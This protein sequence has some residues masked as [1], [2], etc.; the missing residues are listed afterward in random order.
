[1][2]LLVSDFD[3]TFFDDNYLDNIKFV[4]SIRNNTKFVIATGRN[5]N[6]LKKS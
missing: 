2:N 3:G 1:M 4:E 6:F 5:F